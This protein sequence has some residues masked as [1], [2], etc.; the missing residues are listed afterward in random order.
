MLLFFFLSSKPW[1]HQ[2]SLTLQALV[3][4]PIPQ[5]CVHLCGAD[6]GVQFCSF[7]WKVSKS[8][9]AS[10]QT[11]IPAPRALAV[12]ITQDS[13]LLNLDAAESSECFP[14]HTRSLRGC[15]HH[16]PLPRLWVQPPALLTGT[17]C[18]E[19]P[20]PL[21]LPWRNGWKSGISPA[22]N[23]SPHLCLT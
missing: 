19:P 13:I 20:L 4:G 15:E 11:R 22:R 17:R 21:R 7:A 23:T 2:V 12:E 6:D 9:V 3:D 14:T 18:P 8:S 16:C 5:Y 10:R 1:S